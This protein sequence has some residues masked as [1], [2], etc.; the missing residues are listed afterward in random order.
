MLGDKKLEGE[1]RPIR[2]LAR[3]RTPSVDV[4][5]KKCPSSENQRGAEV[6]D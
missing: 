6:T 3:S 4:S 1:A 2:W 5:A